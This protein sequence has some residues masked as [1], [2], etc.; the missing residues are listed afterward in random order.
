MSL[1]ATTTN[2]AGDAMKRGARL[3]VYVPYDTRDLLQSI[4][5]EDGRKVS[6]YV[7]RVLVEHLRMVTQGGRAEQHNST[8]LCTPQNLPTYQDH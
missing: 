2:R 5:A 6:Q 4:A 8:P 7:C 3:E 1:G